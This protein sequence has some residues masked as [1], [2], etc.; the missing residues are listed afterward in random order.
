MGFLTSWGHSLFLLPPDR[1]CVGQSLPASL[2]TQVSSHPFPLQE[3][4]THFFWTFPMRSYNPQI[5]LPSEFCSE[6]LKFS[7]FYLSLTIQTCSWSIKSHLL[8]LL[9]GGYY[10]HFEGSASFLKK[11][12]FLDMALGILILWPGIEPALLALEVQNLN[13]W[14]TGEVPG[15]FFFFMM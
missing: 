11:I 15:G 1:E 5:S 13:H 7:T 3:R 12:F 6:F 9:S 2:Q 10:W 8:V 14:T 4:E